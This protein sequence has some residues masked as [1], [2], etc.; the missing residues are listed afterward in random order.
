MFA[1]IKWLAPWD[2]RTRHQCRHHE[3]ARP[4][5]EQ[6]LI[7]GTRRDFF[8]HKEL[9]TISK[10]LK[11]S[12]WPCTVWPNPILQKGSDFSLSIGG[13]SSNCQADH[14]DDHYQNDFIQYHPP[15]Y[16]SGKA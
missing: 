15:V 6:E 8:F 3:D 13:V 12:E 2:D 11:Q 4:D 7:R 10:R 14:E 1:E 9:H 16:H 5:H